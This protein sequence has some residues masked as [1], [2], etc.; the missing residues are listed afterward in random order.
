MERKPRFDDD[1][2]RADKRSNDIARD[3]KTA[4]L[5]SKRMKKE[6]VD[7]ELGG[8]TIPVSK[9]NASNDT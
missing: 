7:Q 1:K 5:K 9:L 6:A 2:I 4:Q 3:T 8:E